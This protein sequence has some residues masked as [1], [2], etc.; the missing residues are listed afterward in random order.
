MGWKTWTTLILVAL[1]AFFGALFYLQNS[2]RKVDLSLD[3]YVAAWR[4]QEP[5]SVPLVVFVSFGVGLL[6]GLTAM[7][8][9]WRRASGRVAELELRLARTGGGPSGSAGR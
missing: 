7:T 5:V 3:L 6:I 9:A 4:L 2:L 8:L 1:S